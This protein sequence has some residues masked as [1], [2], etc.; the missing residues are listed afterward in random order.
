MTTFSDV[1]DAADDLSVDE[2]ETLVEILRR[3]IAKRN[4]DAL[5]RDVVEARAEFQSGQL[6]T[7][8]VSDII[9]EVR[10]ES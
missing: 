1:V 3:R 8:S 6:R 7:S 4:R 10:G 5:V 2:Q 9:D